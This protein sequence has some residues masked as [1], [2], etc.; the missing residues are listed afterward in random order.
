MLAFYSFYAKILQIMSET[1]K[2][3]FSFPPPDGPPAGTENVIEQAVAKSP[4]Q[5][6]RTEFILGVVAGTLAGA[7]ILSGL[8]IITK[9]LTDN[10]VGTD[11]VPT[12]EVVTA[13]SST[14]VTAPETTVDNEGSRISLE[15]IV[16]PD[17][18]V[19][20]T[21]AELIDYA[22]KTEFAEP[23]ADKVLDTSDAILAAPSLSEA[24]TITQKA[25][26]AST[27]VPLTFNLSPGSGQ[28]LPDTRPDI[29]SLL[30]T[31]I[32]QQFYG[33]I[34]A[35]PKGLVKQP[36]AYNL[37]ED[38]LPS[39]TPDGLG[40]NTNIGGAV[41]NSPDENK[42]ILSLDTG[43]T[44]MATLGHELM[45]IVQNRDPE[46]AEH[47]AYR[48]LSRQGIEAFGSESAMLEKLVKLKDSLTAEQY[49]LANSLIMNF[50]ATP[51]P[52]WEDAA[53]NISST[54]SMGYIEES[55]DPMLSLLRHKQLQAVEDMSV[56]GD[57]DFGAT[58]AYHKRF[59]TLHPNVLVGLADGG[60]IDNISPM[61]GGLFGKGDDWNRVGSI[62]PGTH[63]IN[64]GTEEAPEIVVLGARNVHAPTYS[65]NRGGQGYFSLELV[66]PASDDAIDLTI[67]VDT[68]P[69]AQGDTGTIPANLNLQNAPKIVNDIVGKIAPVLLENGNYQVDA[70]ILAGPGYEDQP[71]SYTVIIYP[72]ALANGEIDTSRIV[73]RI[74]GKGIYEP[75]QPK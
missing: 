68:I 38:Y 61:E 24:K 39:D 29:D 13:P 34:A 9:N 10:Q 1:E 60:I 48:E 37:I 58:V 44:D 42:H 73:G 5:F 26:L 2:E 36:T 71:E 23:H 50:A 35:L 4:R 27:G 30:Y 12:P 55:S 53:Y 41:L 56:A 28:E 45:H 52:T 3:A 62:E 6:T 17:R 49:A 54:F 21:V 67:P 72:E 57:A 75:A 25:I 47:G 40:V 51:D 18:K 8:Q 33:T 70:H 15:T 59:D 63:F 14:Q 31:S 22:R 74:N 11:P 7:D 69:P 46:Y 32:L 43:M 20:Y 19:E 65:E 64:I 66:L 16:S